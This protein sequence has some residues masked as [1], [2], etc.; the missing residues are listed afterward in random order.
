M[1]A[2][3]KAAS[4]AQQANPREKDATTTPRSELFMEKSL[5]S[6]SFFNPEMCVIP[7]YLNRTESV[8]ISLLYLMD[9]WV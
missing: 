9:S 3:A 4:P 5:S 7:M 8:F 2:K 6:L 1:W